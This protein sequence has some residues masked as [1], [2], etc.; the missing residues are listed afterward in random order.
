MLK[1]YVRPKIVKFLRG[2]KGN[3]TSVHLASFLRDVTELNL[4]ASIHQD[5][6][7]AHRLRA[8]IR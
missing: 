1:T 8:N 2:N 3:F 6:Q 5:N 7:E 4:K